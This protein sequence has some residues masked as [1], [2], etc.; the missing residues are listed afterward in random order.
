MAVEDP[1]QRYLD[2][3]PEHIGRQPAVAPRKV[4]AYNFGPTVY[5]R[6]NNPSG[7]FIADVVPT[8]FDAIG[9]GTVGS[10]STTVAV[11]DAGISFQLIADEDVALAILTTLKQ[12]STWLP[13]VRHAAF[14]PTPA[15]P[16]E[17]THE[18]IPFVVGGRGFAEELME[19]VAPPP[20]ARAEAIAG[21][22]S[23]VPDS[24]RELPADAT[25]AQIAQRLA[26][27]SRLSD[28]ELARLFRV[29]RETFQR[30]RTGELQNPTPR[31]RRRLG[32][33]LRVLDDVDRRG[34]RVD[35]WLRNLG[36]GSRC[37]PYQL[38]EQGRIDD[39]E[40][41]AAHLPPL[42]PPATG[43]SPDGEVVTRAHGLPGF[44]PRE[45]EAH[46]DLVVDD[47]EDWI[48]VEAEVVDDD[49]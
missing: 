9:A 42:A 48:D 3:S 35:Q 1:V 32:L 11:L 7:Y 17:G 2:V 8:G 24:S 34:V 10:R 12:Q 21:V 27:L 19:P 26:L 29:A 47:D 13:I 22:R 43:V 15:L 20:A 33:L 38:L 31:N 25:V 40:Q 45:S 37:T 23:D 39:V 41:L 6:S 30:W 16:I 5:V 44:T 36:A 4:L 14:D 28:A 49:D 18:G 46:A